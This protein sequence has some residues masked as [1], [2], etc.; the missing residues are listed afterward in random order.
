MPIEPT[1]ATAHMMV[2]FL[3]VTVDVKIASYLYSVLYK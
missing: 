2:I 1:P 3:Y